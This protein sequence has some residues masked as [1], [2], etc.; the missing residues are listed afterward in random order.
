MK[1]TYTLD[2]PIYGVDF[3]SRLRF[4]PIRYTI[5]AENLKQCIQYLNAVSANHSKQAGFAGYENTIVAPLLTTPQLC[6]HLKI[7]ERTARTWRKRGKLPFV[8]K[9]RAILFDLKVVLEALKNVK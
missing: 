6:K 2:M 5:C 8:K 4:K 9:D 1:I 7:S 3:Y